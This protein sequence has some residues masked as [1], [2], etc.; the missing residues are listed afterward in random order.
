VITEIDHIIVAIDRDEQSRVTTTL[1]ENGF[2][3]G[4][5]GRHPSGTANENIAFA[6]GAFL[7]L[8]YEQ[9][10]G[11]GP[12]VWFAETPRIQGIGFATTE[13]EEGVSRFRNVPGSWDRDFPKV[14]TSGESVSVRA[15]GPLPLE[16][17]YPFLMDRPAPTFGDRGA[18]AK[19]REVTF[20]GQEHAAWRERMLA[21]F[22]LPERDGALAVGDV[23]LTFEEGPHPA[24]RLSLAFDVDGPGGTIPLAGGA[25]V[26]NPR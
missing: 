7:E 11:S 1:F 20:A 23:L 15:A 10:T 2:A 4:D 12:A 21:W 14:L 9:E 6:P 22:A 26:L 17:F 24:I 3:H 13:Y 16:E 18:T 8:L 25:I 5:A 19:L